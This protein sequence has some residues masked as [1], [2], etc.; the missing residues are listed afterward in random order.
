MKV[1]WPQIDIFTHKHISI[2]YS[3]QLF[4]HNDATWN[5]LGDLVP[6]HHMFLCHSE[7]K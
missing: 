5:L 7:C 4:T 2:S 6:N 3:T 1:Y